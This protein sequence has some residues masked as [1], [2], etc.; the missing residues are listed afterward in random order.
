MS[1]Q[2]CSVR[3][4]GTWA[5]L[6]ACSMATLSVQAIAD[7]EFEILAFDQIRLSGSEAYDVFSANSA[8][9]QARIEIRRTIDTTAPSNNTLDAPGNPQ[10][11]MDGD[12]QVAEPPAAIIPERC[13][14]V[15]AVGTIGPRLLTRGAASLA[16][17]V[18][19]IDRNSIVTHN[20]FRHRFTDLA[21]GERADARFAITIPPDQF[22]PPGVYVSDMNVSVASVSASNP[23]SDTIGSNDIVDADDRDTL[24]VQIEVLNAARIGFAGTQGRHRVVDFG[25]LVTNATPTI[26]VALLV[27]A[28]SPYELR[29]RS[30]N[31]GRL[32]NVKAGRTW[33]VPYELS[34]GS[35]LVDLS[36]GESRVS[37]KAATGSSGWQVPLDFRILDASNR[38]AGRYEDRLTV[39]ITPSTSLP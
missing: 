24:S 30:E 5:F 15:L 14:A 39:E 29:F 2:K 7:C 12:L 6:C 38:R 18:Q 33:E 27:Q 9:D 32:I 22:V 34:L 28:T 35:E 3:T 17:D 36:A 13:D 31:A 10:T 4:P 20:G 25:K 23:V 26:P 21:P 8:S 1:N 37:L 19:P 16:F 11:V